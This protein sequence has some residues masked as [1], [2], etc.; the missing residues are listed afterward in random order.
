MPSVCHVQIMDDQWETQVIEYGAINITGFRIVD[1][2]R[3]YVRDFLDGWRRLDAQTSKGAGK[4][5]ISAQAALMYDAVFVLVD[6][7][8]KL[9]KKKPDQ[10]RAIGGGGGGGGSKKGGIG[11][12]ANGTGISNAQQSGQQLNHRGV[13]CN[14]TKTMIDAWEHG[15]KISRYLRKVELEGL[16]GEIRFNEEGRRINY[17]LNVVEMSVNSAMVKVAEWS[18]ESKFTSI[19]AKFVRLYTN[20]VA[21][22]LNRTFVVTSIIEE[23]YT[24]EVQGQR[25]EGNQRY[26]GYCKDLAD[27][28]AE[29][30]GITCKCVSIVYIIS[31][32]CC[33]DLVG[34]GIIERT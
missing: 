26:E 4:D 16:T 20:Q 9:L 18:D 21:Q 12:L 24:M 30:T 29:R 32:M 23:P 19:A 7:F 11:H 17:T 6:A 15:D 28:V 31:S 13:E 33:E 3:R 22:Q 14:I 10:F 25:L 8:T 2:Q 34:N 1:H 27:L 5:S